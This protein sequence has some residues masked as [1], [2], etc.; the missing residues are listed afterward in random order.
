[1]YYG[2]NREQRT[3]EALLAGFIEWTFESKQNESSAALV[4]ET[5]KTLRYRGQHMLVCVRGRAQHVKQGGTAEYF[6]PGI[7]AGIFLCDPLK[8]TLT[9]SK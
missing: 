2:P 4:W 6:C 9:A 5:G 7:F 8:N 1:M 3:V